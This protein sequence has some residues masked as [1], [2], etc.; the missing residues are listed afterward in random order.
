MHFRYQSNAYP[1]PSIAW[2][3]T[4]SLIQTPKINF[5][6][7][8]LSWPVCIEFQDFIVMWIVLE[9]YAEVWIKDIR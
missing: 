7:I 8:T 5:T 9:E 6:G 1:F 4:Y 3:Y 2:E